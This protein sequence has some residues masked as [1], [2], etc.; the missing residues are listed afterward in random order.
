VT[1]DGAQIVHVTFL[2]TGAA[3]AY[4]E[5]FCSCANCQAARNE[6]GRSLRKRSSALVNDDLLIDL[7]PDI[8]SASQM[9]LVRLTNVR[10]C[11]Q[12]H[13]HADHLDL[14]HLLSRS[15][16][17]GVVGAPRLHLYASAR[18]LEKAQE[19]FVRDLS[20]S[21]LLAAESQE[22][23]N[24]EIHQ[25]APFERFQVGPYR[26]IA[27]PANHAPELGA[28]LYAV[29]IDE[30]TVFYGTD[31]AVLFEETWA[32]FH[33]LSLQFDLV[34]L[35]HTYGPGQSGNDHLNAAQ[36]AEHV[37]RMKDEALLSDHG[38]VFATHIA[39]DGNPH[40]TELARFAEPRGYGIAY[41]G[42]RVA[43]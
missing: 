8:M 35:D 12:T 27:F 41:D 38:R 42:L 30:C 37:R 1:H 2:G 34:V 6:G 18:T 16:A 29:E 17:F 20:A 36:V 4:P 21:E 23:L 28:M 24:L 15:P 13:P 32:A 10:Y 7:G 5:A 26:A 25:V 14:S 43:V 40:H 39:H 31:T 11:L 19:T 9:H 3:N 22:A 33:R